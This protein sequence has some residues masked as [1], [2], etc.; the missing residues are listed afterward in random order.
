MFLALA[1]MEKMRLQDKTRGKFKAHL[2][3]RLCFNTCGHW[4]LEMNTDLLKVT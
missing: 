2:I 1:L 4:G 3:H